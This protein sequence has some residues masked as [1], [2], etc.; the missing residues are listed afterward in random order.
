[1]ILYSDHTLELLGELLKHTSAQAPPRPSE[2]SI[3]ISG[4]LLEIQ[5][6]RPLP[7]LTGSETL[8]EAAQPTGF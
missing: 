6:L 7:R 2:V 3:C 1:M 8:R 4:N 5:I